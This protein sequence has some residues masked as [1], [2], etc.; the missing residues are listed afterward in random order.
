MTLTATRLELYDCTT[1]K[2]LAKNQS[3]PYQRDEASPTL[4]PQREFPRSS[5]SSVH[6]ALCPFR[7]VHPVAP[8]DQNTIPTPPTSGLSCGS[9]CRN[10]LIMSIGHIHNASPLQIIVPTSMFQ[11]YGRVVV[12]RTPLHTV[13]CHVGAVQGIARHHPCLSETVNPSYLESSMI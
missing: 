12:I 7:G 1:M 5:T 10:R 11:A 9:R 6:N 13:T 8:I 2:R 4:N 3:S